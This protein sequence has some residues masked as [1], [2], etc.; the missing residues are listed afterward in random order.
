MSGMSLASMEAS[1]MLDTFHFF[2]EEDVRY[3]SEEQTIFMDSFRTNIYREFYKKEYKYASK[4]SNN[5]SGLDSLD[6]PLTSDDQLGREENI[7]VFSPREKVAKPYTP[8]TAM[9]ADDIKPF[10]S[11]LDAPIN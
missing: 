8:P 2:F 9:S 1:D 7:K 10:G 3:V 5:A 6:D 4:R 11:V